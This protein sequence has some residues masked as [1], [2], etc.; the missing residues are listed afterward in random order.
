MLPTLRPTHP[1]SS[2]CQPN[3]RRLAG[4][5]LS[6]GS[7]LRHLVRRMD[8]ARSY[9]ESTSPTS[10]MGFPALLSPGVGPSPG[11]TVRSRA[12]TGSREGARPFEAYAARSRRV[13]ESVPAP[14]PRRGGP[15]PVRLLPSD[16]RPS[17]LFRGPG[18]CGGGRLPG[19]LRAVEA[20]ATQAAVTRPMGGDLAGRTAARF[21]R[22]RPTSSLRI[23]RGPSSNRWSA[24]LDSRA[25]LRRP[26]PDGEHPSQELYRYEPQRDAAAARIPLNR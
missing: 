1:N 6:L 13:L 12:R 3:A 23:G 5:S 22:R 14:R 20:P 24:L 7:G 21:S 19:L 8:L 16:P 17:G 2:G 4:S 26:I 10:E 9:A 11:H 15:A 18:G 25:S